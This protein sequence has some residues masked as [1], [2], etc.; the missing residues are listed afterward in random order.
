VIFSETAQE[1]LR[2]RTTSLPALFLYSA[3]FTQPNREPVWTLRGAPLVRKQC[4]FSVQSAGATKT[5]IVVAV[6]RVVV[7]A[8]CTAKVVSVIVVPRAA[9]QNTLTRRH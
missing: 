5:V 6:F 4:G 8:V 9:A 1:D 3:R 7:V 2:H